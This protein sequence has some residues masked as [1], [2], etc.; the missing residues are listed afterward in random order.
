M[1]V[2]LHIVSAEPIVILAKILNPRYAAYKIKPY[3]TSIT[4]RAAHCAC[5]VSF[6]CFSLW[7]QIPGEHKLIGGENIRLRIDARVLDCL[8][9]VFY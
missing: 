4:Q 6:T 3:V 8:R 2:Y 5:N 1:F 9:E 7:L